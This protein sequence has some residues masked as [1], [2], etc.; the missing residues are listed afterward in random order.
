MS[1][2]P[3][4]TD[5][6]AGASS[7]AG[8]F[9]VDADAHLRKLAASMFPT[10]AQLPVELVRAALGRGA[11]TVAVEIRRRR[12][13]VVDDGAAIADEEWR[14][15]CC[16][17]DGS[18]PA[19][20]R[21]QAIAVLHESARP[22]IGPLAALLPGAREI[23]IASPGAGSRPG[24]RLAGGTLR[25]IPQAG[26]QPGTRI[27][28]RRRHGDAGAERRL[29]AELCAGVDA[30]ISLNGRAI[31]KK[32]ILRRALVRKALKP[33]LS[34]GAALSAVSVPAR[35]EICR[36]WLLDRQIPWQLFTS[37]SCAGLVF[38]AAL[39]SRVPATAAEFTALADAAAGLYGWL[40]SRY[41]SFPLPW[42]ERIEELVFRRIRATGDARLSSAFAPFRLLGSPRRL[43]LDEVRRRAQAGPLTALP[44]GDDPA[45]FPGPF[46]D[47][48]LLTPRQIDFLANDAGVPLSV[49][50][51]AADG[52]GLAARLAAFLRRAGLRL[53][54]RLP[55]R[56][57]REAP[58]LR[59]DEERLC[60]EMESQ[61]REHAPFP[62]RPGVRVAMTPG[63][64]L[65]PSSWRAGAE[66][67]VLWLRRE[68]P[69]V[70]AAARRV[71]RDRANAELAWMAL[72][73]RPLLTAGGS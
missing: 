21:E 70:R 60:R 46:H 23:L 63:R 37:A 62:L 31:E 61:L 41:P 7:L 57:L 66:R 51:A 69:L 27:V 72:A 30:V 71:G 36:I 59:P 68:H 58:G 52:G 22:G 12:L 48:L 39:E 10:P 32:P 9:S 43:S 1:E 16:A 55:R 24:L 53:L 29:L 17:L 33:G 49:P 6:A 4:A 20:E 73:P 50:P 64:G 25:S 18:R 26:G 19:L 3:P 5:A 40:C 45:R 42:Q 11:G 35:G 34:A 14:A 8:L 44:A 67:S 15:L 38:D 47:A 65:F 28:V 56:R 54:A 13:D 2:L